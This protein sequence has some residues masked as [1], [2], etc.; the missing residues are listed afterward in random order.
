MKKSVIALMML[1]GLN[2]LSV[3]HAATPGQ[4]AFVDRM[5][6]QALG[7]APEPS[8]FASHIQFINS[9]F[10]TKEQA[11]QVARGF[12]DSAEF[13]SFNLTPT[14]AIRRVYR[15][16][17]NREAEPEGLANAVAAVNAGTSV[18]AIAASFTN[19]QEF[20]T[21]QL[22]T[23]CNGAPP[24][25]CNGAAVGATKEEY[26]PFPEYDFP[27]QIGTT[28]D[29]L[30]REVLLCQKTRYRVYNKFV[31]NSQG[32]WIQE[33]PRTRVFDGF[34]SYQSSGFMCF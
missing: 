8:G 32:A 21:T 18:A 34:E 19:S 23:Y 30:G 16:V 1:S 33:F 6:R 27:R 9:G 5:Y 11:G 7:R 28:K 26:W 22:P 29:F 3:A 15:A 10:C 14:E 24:V 12:F 13:K 20:I 17:L 31:C 25:N 4:E 2:V